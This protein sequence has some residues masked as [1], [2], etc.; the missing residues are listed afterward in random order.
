MR[1]A[2]IGGELLGALLDSVAS[3]ADDISR[4]VNDDELARL[5][6]V[7]VLY[8]DSH[9]ARQVVAEAF[10]VIPHLHEAVIYGNASVF[11]RPV[12]VIG[13]GLIALRKLPL[14][15]IRQKR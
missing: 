1:F 4:L 14:L 13:N 11:A 15:A 6:Y 12:S 7:T 3:R 2:D 5:A 9:L 10:C 8:G